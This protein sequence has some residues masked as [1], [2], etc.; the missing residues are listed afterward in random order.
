[1]ASKEPVLSLADAQE[2]LAGIFGRIEMEQKEWQEAQTK[3]LQPVEEEMDVCVKEKCYKLHKAAAKHQKN[4]TA[5]VHKWQYNFNTA[6][7]ESY[8]MKKL[9]IDTI[10][11]MAQA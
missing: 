5:G 11:E 7:F 3:A 10:I 4:L 6:D 8:Y 2:K 1:M 9:E